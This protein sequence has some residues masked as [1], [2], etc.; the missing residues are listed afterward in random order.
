MGQ[1]QSVGISA[2]GFGAQVGFKGSDITPKHK[3]EAFLVQAGVDV[4]KVI[5]QNDE[6]VEELF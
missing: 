4:V 2:F 6:S 1:L 5:R 3:I